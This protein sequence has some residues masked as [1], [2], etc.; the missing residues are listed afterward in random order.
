MITAPPFSDDTPE[1]RVRPSTESVIRASRPVRSLRRNVLH[2]AADVLPHALLVR[3]GSRKRPRVAL[4]FDDGPDE[5]TPRYLD[6][7]DRLGV[8]ATFFVLGAACVRHPQLLRAIVARG[9]EVASHGYTHRVFP[10]LTR[11]DLRLELSQVDDVIPPSA[12]GRPFVR[13]PRGALSLRSLFRCAAAGYTTVLWSVD[14]GDCRTTSA[15]AVV[16]TVA[17]AGAG[18]IVLLHEGQSWTLDALSPMVSA[19]RASRLEPT[20]VGDLLE[21]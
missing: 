17:G 10:A 12:R 8:R 15:R 4:T 1:S 9:H 18:D 19:L 14:S 6:A 11:S 3:R 21:E 7:L 2:V 13:P 20:T 16:E 5:H